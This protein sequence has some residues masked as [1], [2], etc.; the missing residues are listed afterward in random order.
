MQEFKKELSRLYVEAVFEEFGGAEAFFEESE[1]HLEYFNETWSQDIELVGRVLRAHLVVEYFLTEYIQKINPRLPSVM[2][3]G[4]TFE[5]KIKLLPSEDAAIQMS[6][7]GMRHLNKIRNRIA[8]SLGLE[9]TNEDR[10]AFLG[11]QLFSGMR[12]AKIEREML[13]GNEP[14]D[15]LE[16]FSKLVASF[17]QSGAN[18]TSERMAAAMKRVSQNEN[19]R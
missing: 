6:I 15:V 16:D 18:G 2:E 8:H 19:D 14:I 1:A 12:K 13:V 9:L 5:Q 11:N 10:S 4:L 3:A 7:P 17:L